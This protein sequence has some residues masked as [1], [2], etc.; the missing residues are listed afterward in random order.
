MIDT[1]ATSILN[2]QH[3][4]WVDGDAGDSDAHATLVGVAMIAYTPVEEVRRGA[5]AM[6]RFRRRL[7][8]CRRE[9]CAG[10]LWR[11]PPSQ[12]QPQ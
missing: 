2:A 8:L 6:K 5:S 3:D 11:K 7:G 9:Y 4:S 1:R 10:V 12:P